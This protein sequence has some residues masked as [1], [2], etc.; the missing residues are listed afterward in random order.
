MVRKV[1]T[2][3]QTQLDK[4]EEGYKYSVYAPSSEVRNTLCVLLD[5]KINIFC[6]TACFSWAPSNKLLAKAKT[7]TYQNLSAVDLP[8]RLYWRLGNDQV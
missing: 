5:A 4:G 7:V 2:D 8:K 3:A 6:S 1:T